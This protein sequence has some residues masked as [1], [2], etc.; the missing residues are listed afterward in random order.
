MHSNLNNDTIMHNTP[1]TAENGEIYYR[2]IGENTILYRTPLESN[3]SSNVYFRLPTTYF[4]K[5]NGA[6]DELFLNVTYRDFT[7]YVL[8]DNVER[9]YSTPA[10]PYAVGQ[11]FSVQ[12]IAN[13]VLRSKPTTQS[14]Y[15]GTIPF[16]ATDIEFFGAIEGEQ[17]NPELSNIWYYCRYTSFEQGILTGYVYAPLTQNLVETPENTEVV[18]MEPSTEVNGDGVIAPELQNSTSIWLIIGLTIPA[19]ILLLLVLKPSK[20]RHQRAAKRQIANLN[21]LSIPEKTDK[22]EFDF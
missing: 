12:G 19:L 15:I 10:T 13:L 14:E 20:R 18:D 6:Y 5:F 9:V 3:E 21:K 4:V 22:D 1:K 16:N 11:T 8:A 17:A 7:G 2:I